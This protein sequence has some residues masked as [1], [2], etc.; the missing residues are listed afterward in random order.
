[1]GDNHVVAGPIPAIETA[2]ENSSR[3]CPR[4][5]M[6]RDAA[7]DDGEG[8]IPSGGTPRAELAA[9]VCPHRSAAALS[10]RHFYVTVWD[11]SGLHNRAAVFDSLVAFFA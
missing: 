7:Q 3:T 11:G 1:M 6:G 8:S 5:R 10:A 4:P 9:M 2:L